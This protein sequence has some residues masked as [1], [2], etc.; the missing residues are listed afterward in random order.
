MLT[1]KFTHTNKLIPVN[2]T[3]LYSSKRL[4]ALKAKLSDAKSLMDSRFKG[5][6][7][8]YWKECDPFKSEKA[9]VAKIGCTYNITN[10]WLKCYEMLNE[11]DLIPEDSDRFVHFDNASFPGSFI[12]ST[13]H[14]IMT[15][16]TWG[17]NYQWHANSLIDANELNA[18]PIDDKYKLY[19]NYPD[20]W[21][22]D[23]NC[24]GDVLLVANQQAFA[25]KLGGKIDLYTS[26]LGFDVSSNYNNQEMIQA[27]AN[28]GQIIAGLI[29]LKPG[30]SFITKQYTSFEMITVSVMFA[31]SQLFD[32]FYLCKPMTSR[33][34]NSETY[35]VGKGFKAAVTMD[36]PYIVA[37]LARLNKTVKLSVPL[38]LSTDYP[39]QYLKNIILACS[40]FERQLEKIKTDVELC[41]ECVSG[42]H[43]GMP[44]KNPIVLNSRE[45]RVT[46][47]LNWYK[48][49][50]IMP[51]SA[52]DA[53]DMIDAYRQL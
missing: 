23:S 50:A 3:K 14:Y 46:Q 9:I 2:T 35:L 19:S 36:H 21:L 37:M 27:R 45:Q 29:T 4:T 24:N 6:F 16:R 8:T 1:F 48:K 43:T 12:A 42:G 7:P 17:N 15:K 11:F 51:L 41:D 30:G 18:D 20:N 5:D 10:A 25:D 33:E 49:M 34:A 39:K 47:L 44:Y 31:L 32:E 52:D 40:V 28:I 26:D 13:H 38:F 53:L 22:M